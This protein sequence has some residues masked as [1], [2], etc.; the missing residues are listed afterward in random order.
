MEQEQKQ[1]W[2]P[3]PN[4]RPKKEIKR[5]ENVT[6]RFSPI[7]LKK[8]GTVAEQE[9]LRRANLIIKALEEFYDKYDY[10]FDDNGNLVEG[11]Y[12]VTDDFEGFE[13]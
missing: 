10:R 4:G 1:K 11:A 3:N 5:S 6:F 13:F 9:H 8:L 12:E 7:E 2:C